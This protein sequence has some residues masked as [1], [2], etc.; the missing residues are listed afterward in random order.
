MPE[1]NRILIID[2]DL[3]IWKS[4]ESI[5]N[6][7]SDQTESNSPLEALLLEN[8]PQQK[9]SGRYQLSFSQ[10]GKEG[11][12]ILKKALEEENPFAVTFI[13]M[14]MPPGWNGVETACAIREIDPDVE[15]VII[16]AYADV[17]RSEMVDAI[18]SPDKLLYLRKPFDT[19]ELSQIALQLT[20][21]RRL[22]D[23]QKTDQARIQKL[24][25]EI[26]N[27]RDYMDRIINNLPF[28][29]VG[30]NAN[31]EVT[32]WNQAAES[33]TGHRHVDTLLHPVSSFFPGIE[34]LDSEIASALDHGQQIRME[35]VSMNLS[36][37]EMLCDIM[38]YPF[39]SEENPGVVMRIED[40]TERTKLQDIMVQSDK[41]LT[42]GGLAAGMAHEINTPL[43]SIIQ[44]AQVIAN[45]ID[46]EN[47]K[48]QEIATACGTD[49]ET[50]HR[51]MEQ[52][53]ICQLLEGIRDG[54]GRTSK[55][56]KSMLSFS[57]KGDT[58]IQQRVNETID[59]AL[60]LSRSDYDLKKVYRFHD[61]NIIR[62]YADDLPPINIDRT[63]FE[64]V[65][66]NLI[67]N[68]SQA[69]KDM[70]SD[71]QPSLTIST[72]SEADSVVIRLK[73][74][75]PGIDQETQKRIFDPFFTTKEIGV[76]TG[77]GLS[78]AY[79]IITNQ[80]GGEISVESAP[81]H[82]ATFTIRLPVG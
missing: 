31:G 32:L 34:N 1:N 23:Q 60:E 72:A 52:R 6:A 16:T 71:H 20:E 10:Q 56:V 27:T 55:I 57:H 51:Y 50:V 21:K 38:L 36:D 22:A 76:G 80:H 48:N 4:Y 26:S 5:L 68:A 70:G 41:M 61:I 66:M 47:N 62:D 30:V 7:I 79:F 24:L 11:Y 82:G 29:L 54:G 12:E 33:V 28:M 65:I 77:L 58:A 53:G 17:S 75:G 63:K 19:E 78:L 15:I 39:K 43:G 74:N 59:E 42:V 37:K 45:R 35:K 9:R 14:R 25:E 64:Q 3:S 73:D 2:D 8:D 67:R 49:I 81:G 69:M 18:G 13:D 46:K 40:I 44:S